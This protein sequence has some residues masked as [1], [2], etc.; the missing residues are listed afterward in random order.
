MKN[1]VN[2]KSLTCPNCGAQ[3][4]VT[5]NTTDIVY[6]GTCGT[7]CVITGLNVNEEI[8]KKNNIN[9]GIPVNATPDQIHQ[10]V[11]NFVTTS[12]NF[13]ISVLENLEIS[14]VR[15]VSV[16]AY[17][18]T[19]SAFATCTYEAGNQRKQADGTSY[20]EWTQMSTVAN[21][22]KTVIV[23]GNNNYT[24][25]IHSFYGSLDPA[26]LVDI[27]FLDYPDGT[28]TELFNVPY[29][30]AFNQY[31]RPSVDEGIRAS[32]Q[33]PLN[34]KKY[35]N[36][37]MGPA[38]IQKEY[39]ARISLGIYIVDCKFEHQNFSI[40][41]NSNASKYL[42][43]VAAPEDDARTAFINDLIASKRAVKSTFVSDVFHGG[44]SKAKENSATHKDEKYQLQQK[45]DSVRT[46]PEKAK[47]EFIRRRCK[48]KGVYSNGNDN[49]VWDS[50]NPDV[51][52][53]VSFSQT[54]KQSV[55]KPAQ[56]TQSIQ[57][58]SMATTGLVF[59][60]I[61]NVLAMLCKSDNSASGMF[62]FLY[63]NTMI[64]GIIFSSIGI[65]KSQIIGGKGKAVTGLVLSIVS[66]LFFI[67]SI[68]TMSAGV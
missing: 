2:I 61:A 25:T 65:T 43:T 50:Y 10:A 30:T 58:N 53:D 18:F 56:S 60:I 5:K 48:F 7:K 45:I 52:K 63:I 31:V 44:F 37:S 28:T 62:I 6:C 16:P 64:L 15:V 35:R 39:E 14:A 23:C 19:V 40:Y 1:E 11:F 26:N 3:L 67:I 34:G 4:S 41:M 51:P 29:V 46:E 68:A 36:F 24:D 66:F 55:S 57:K 20:T 12:K 32:A 33:Q 17:L 42:A 38:N 21:Y 13:P 47:E 49:F 54:S 9:S 8:L 27:E 59:G 22:S